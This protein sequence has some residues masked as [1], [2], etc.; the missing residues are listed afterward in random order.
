MEIDI[1]YF[2][3][4]RLL[5]KFDFFKEGISLYDRHKDGYKFL[6]KFSW[7]YFF[8]SKNEKCKVEDVLEFE[9]G[10]KFLILEDDVIW[11][12]AI[13]SFRDGKFYWSRTRQSRLYSLRAIR[14]KDKL[15]EELFNIKMDYGGI[16]SESYKIIDRGDKLKKLGI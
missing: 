9:N 6:E 3:S 10:L 7:S 15:Y 13:P 4:E 5:D 16:F 1:F 12:D 14:E 2:D 11:Y 8:S